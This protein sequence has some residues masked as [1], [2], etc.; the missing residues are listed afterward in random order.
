M[1]PRGAPPEIAETARDLSDILASISGATLPVAAEPGDGPALVLGVWDQDRSLPP[2]AYHV[3]LD[4]NRVF[5]SGGSDQGVING[6]YAFLERE[7]GCR[8]YVPGPLGEHIPKRETITVSDLDLRDEPDFES[9]TGFGMHPDEAT[10]R[11][12]S[13]RNRLDGFPQHFHSHNW[14]RIVPPQLLDERPELFALVGKKR[15]PKQ[16]C[17]THPE[18]LQIA[19]SAARQYLDEHPEMVSFSL[20]PGDFRGFCRCERCRALDNVLGVNPFVPGGSMTDR[21]VYFLNQVATEVVKTHPGRR[22]AFYAYMIYTRPPEGV[23]PHPMLLPVLVHTPWD[24]CM[25]HPIDDPDCERNRRFAEAVAGWHEQTPKLYLYDYWAHYSLCGHHGVVHNIERGLPWLRRHG[26]VGF[27]GEMHPQRW[28]QPLNFYLP[29]RI[30]WNVDTDVET[31]VAEFYEHM[32]GPAASE[33]AAFARMFEDA[34]AG[35]PKDADHDR[36]LAFI[37]TMT[38]AFFDGARTLL[39]R[40]EQ[41][42]KD[43]DIAPGERYAIGERIRR[44]RYGLRLS[45][46]IALE[47]QSRAAGRMERVIDYLESFLAILNEI[48]A[49]PELADTVA[50]PLARRMTE[51]ELMRLVPYRGI[52]ERAIPEPEQRATI[53]RK[54]DEGRTREVARSLGYWGDW[55]LVG[56]WPNDEGNLLDTPYPPENGIN[57]D[58]TFSAWTGETSWR[59][60][61]SQSPYGVV[62]L[63]R[64]FYPEDSEFTVAYAFTTIEARRDADVRLDVTCDDDIVLWLND[65]LVFAGGAVTGNFDIHVDAHLRAGENRVLAKVLNKPHAFN[66]SLR[67]ADEAGLPH[68]AVVWE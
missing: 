63:E 9:I 68:D 39:Q 60:H 1:I 55:Y 10:G 29:A 46:R 50:L 38:P 58:E 35:V 52:W 3:W 33:I 37:H 41:T 30:A 47:K 2:L 24:Y 53:R 20:S 62:D 44:Y 57:L 21:L 17:T 65:D 26:V 64:F 11:L 7:L 61:R 48:A 22:L 16:F 4:G 32:F 13:R 23:K 31:I 14:S 25:H 67:I 66:F 8:W 59:L 40:A 27:Y 45:E 42:V 18:A 28:T 36:H 51:V 19:V 5:F 15:N 49:E 43:V 34:M 54:L 56:L 12:W 6:V